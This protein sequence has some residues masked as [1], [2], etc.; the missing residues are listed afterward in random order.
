MSE[1]SEMTRRIVERKAKLMTIRDIAQFIKVS[2][3]TLRRWITCNFF[4][5]PD[6]LLGREHKWSSDT[7]DKWIDAQQQLNEIM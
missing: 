1:V 2:K 5:G 6:Y 3:S 4:P 7:V